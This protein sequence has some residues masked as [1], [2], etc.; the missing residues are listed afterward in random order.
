MRKDYAAEPYEKLA[1]DNPELKASVTLTITLH[2]NGALSVGGPVGDRA[3]C[4]A[5]LDNARDAVKRQH[6][7]SLII[8]AHDVATDLVR[9]A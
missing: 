5:L 2:A 9:R 4:Y 3:L 6:E 1:R 7:K 8:P